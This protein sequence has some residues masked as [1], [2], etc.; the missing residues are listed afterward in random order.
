[1]RKTVYFLVKPFDTGNDHP[2]LE[3][4]RK[5]LS[6][7]DEK[8]IT[9]EKPKYKNWL[10]EAVDLPNRVNKIKQEIGKVPRG[11][12]IIIVSASLGG[13]E[14]VLACEDSNKIDG[15]VI[16]NGFFDKGIVDPQL[17]RFR[18]LLSIVKYFNGT[19]RKLESGLREIDFSKIK[20]KVL[21][22]LTEDDES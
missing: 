14:S 20:A 10:E 21:V 6:G 19:L 15:L 22:F 7:D 4:L 18:Y 8:V 17:K 1:M 3:Y 13:L 5:N 16:I 12:T 11:T 2:T 9:V